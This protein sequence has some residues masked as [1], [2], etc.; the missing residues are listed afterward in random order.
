LL[1]AL[2]VPSVALATGPTFALQVTGSRAPFFVMNAKPGNTVPGEVTV[3]NVGAS[4]GVVTLYPTDATTGQTSGA[5]YRSPQE[6]R[7]DVGGW[8]QL[9]ERR[10]TLG[11][12][13]ARTV[14][15]Q[16]VIPTGVRPGQHLGGI[17]AQPDLPRAKVT[18]RRGN[19]TFH[20][21]IR[22]VTIT[23]VE[24]NLP[25]PRTQQLAVTGI[26]AGAEP[27]Y[28]T[29]LV[30]LASTGDALTKG[31]GSLSVTDQHG[32]ALLSRS[33][34]LDTFVPD[35]HIQYP[36]EVPGKALPAGSY[37]AQV[38]LYYTGHYQTRTLPLTVSERELAQAFGSRRTTPP[39]GSGFGLSMIP[40]IIVGVAVLLLGFVLGARASARR[41]VRAAGADGQIP[42]V[43]RRTVKR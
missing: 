2:V 33:F 41:A 18:G 30:G 21:Q 34:K 8:I 36:V 4:T 1:G 23:A 6:P 13:Q 25:G 7:R 22:D 43:P 28:Q 38:T 29:V 15:F 10:L 3:I 19:A 35:T 39:P 37:T 32:Q 26:R 5:V 12:G 40:L 14:R 31:E 42:R 9:S 27:G 20:V 24:V 11:A 17:V 16:V